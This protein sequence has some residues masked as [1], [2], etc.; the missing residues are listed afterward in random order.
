MEENNNNFNEA[1]WPSKDSTDKACSNYF[2]RL[3]YSVRPFC[4]DCEFS[5]TNSVPSIKNKKHKI[6][7]FCAYNNDNSNIK[8][9]FYD[10]CGGYKDKNT[11]EN[12]NKKENFLSNLYFNR[13]RY[14]LNNKD[15]YIKYCKKNNIDLYHFH[16]DFYWRKET[17]EKSFK[18]GNCKCNY[19]KFELAKNLYYM[20]AEKIGDI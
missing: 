19:Q 17:H 9:E 12:F 6:D 8:V 3:P 15:F 20:M 4:K 5:I 13:C 16:K 1:P 18:E 14:I 10:F 2:P 7:Y 11:Q